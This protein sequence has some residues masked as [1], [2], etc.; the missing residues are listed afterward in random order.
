MTR[1]LAVTAKPNTIIGY[2]ASGQPIR[3]H[4]GANWSTFQVTPDEGGDDDD[5]PDDDVDDV[6]ET[7]DEGSGDWTPPTREEWD[8]TQAGL[9][10]NNAENKRLRLL[11][12]ALAARGVDP[13]T[14]EGRTALDELLAGRTVDPDG[15]P[16]DASVKTQITRAVERATAKTETKYK[17]ALAAVAVEAAL[18]RAGYSAGEERLARVMKMIDMDEVDVDDD[19][20]VVGIVD[21]IADIKHDV[22]EWFQGTTKAPSVVRRGAADVDA[23]PRSTKATGDTKTWLERV[24]KQMTGG[25]G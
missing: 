20:Q 19:G 14:D 4:T 10:R 18:S 7:T 17:G 2:R 13:S 11:S 16:A 5:E 25:G 1:T 6:D 23:G 9:K 21:Q 3:L 15:K 22:P 8:R 12:K 24:D